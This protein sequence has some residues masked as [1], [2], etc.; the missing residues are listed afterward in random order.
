M[1]ILQTGTAF[2]GENLPKC[3]NIQNK[4]LEFS[5]FWIFT[6]SIM[7]ILVAKKSSKTSNVKKQQHEGHVAYTSITFLTL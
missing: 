4:G 1:V 7:G 6:P 3:T 2:L 5:D